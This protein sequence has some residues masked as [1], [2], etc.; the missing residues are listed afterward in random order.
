[1][2]LREISLI[3]LLFR[4]F[5]AA[6]F[7]VETSVTKTGLKSSS[8]TA[9]KAPFTFENPF[10]SF[11]DIFQKDS[12]S[13]IKPK[14][15]A[16]ETVETFIQALNSRKDPTYLLSF[17][18]DDI[19]FVDAAFYNP[20]I[21]KDKLL[22]HF[23]LNRGSSPLSTLSSDSGIDI[24][25]DDIVASEKT[26]AEDR[27]NVCVLYHLEKEGSPL[28]DSTSIGF[29]TLEHNLISQVLDVAEPPSPKPGDSGLKLLKTVSSIIGNERIIQKVEGNIDQ[30]SSSVETYFDAW[31][32]RDMRRAASVFT[33]DCFVRDFQYDGEFSGR[34]ELEAHLQRV[35]DS[36]PRSFNFVLD[37]M[38]STRD[39]VGVSWHV[40]NKG[41]PLAFTRGCS[42]YSLDSKSG[43]ITAGY[44]IPEKAPPKLGAFNTVYSKFKEEPIRL[45]PALLW[46]TYMYVL[47]ISDGILPGANALQLE[48]RTWEEVRDLSLN[49]FLVSPLLNLPFSP[50]V[51]PMLEGVFNW[52]LAWAAMFAGFLSDERKNKPNLLPFGPILIGMQFLTSGFLLP[53]LFTRNRETDSEV[54]KDDID[55]ELQAKLGEWRP[56]GVVLGSIGTMSMAWGLFGRPE[57]GEFN[58][59]YQ[60]FIDLLSIDRVGSSFLVDLAIF[61]AFQGWFID[62]DLQRRGVQSDEGLVLRNVGKYVPFFGLAY[63]LTFR[64]ALLASRDEV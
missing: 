22:R 33:I 3:L 27:S 9:A 21:G 31:N 25:V 50:V 47:F 16:Q 41:K 43:L 37:G 42:F 59:R 13:A 44:D 15:S 6:A 30:Q 1:M 11:M 2:K 5:N 57:F 14:S 17:F 40:E 64:P 63:Y 20:I 58:E 34:D 28:E 46:V 8:L 60:S 49:F 35:N 32:R 39:K 19:K 7:S 18:D 56:L 23:Y 12:S 48:Q 10:G 54:Y 61:A 45:V 62:D 52:L 4:S 51:N 38:A 29:Y 36:L 26:S 53:Y 55:G 24:I